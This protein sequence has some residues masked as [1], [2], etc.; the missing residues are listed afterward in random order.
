MGTGRQGI[1][2]LGKR[3]VSTLSS[4]MFLSCCLVPFN[5]GMKCLFSSHHLA[6]ILPNNLA[7]HP[8]QEARFRA[9]TTDGTDSSVEDL[10]LF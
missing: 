3:F 1:T 8:G 4:K 5:L 10:Q 6:Q 9:V 7:I 2:D